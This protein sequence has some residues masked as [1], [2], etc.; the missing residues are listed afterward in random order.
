MASIDPNTWLLPFSSK[1]YNFSNGDGRPWGDGT[2]MAAREGLP[3]PKDP[4]DTGCKVTPLI[5][6]F[7]TMSAIRE[8]LKKAIAFAKAQNTPLGQRGHVYIAGL[9][10]NS[11]RDLSVHNDWHTDPWT[12]AQ[13][14]NSDETAIGLILQLLQAGIQ[15][16]I[17]L[18]LP[19]F[20]TELFGY[21]AHI[22][23][24]YYLADIVRAECERLSKEFNMPG[25]ASLGIV[26]LDIRV[27][28][29]IS[30]AHHQKMLL[31]RV[32]DTN[33]AY[34]G[35]VDLVFTRRDA[36]LWNDTTGT[37]NYEYDPNRWE[38][39]SKPPPQFLAG[40]WQ[41][42]TGIPTLFDLSDKTHRWPTAAGVNY[43]V[44]GK[45]SPFKAK[46]DSDLPEVYGKGDRPETRQ[47]WHDQHLR[48]EGPIVKT[49]EEQFRERWID[50]GRVYD[51]SNIYSRANW[52]DNQVIFSTNQA[53]DND[54]NIKSLDQ[55]IDVPPVPGGTSTVQMWRTIPLRKRK[56]TQTPLFTRGEFTIMA[57][58]A[59]ACQTATQ[60][61]W[62]FDQYFFSRP[63]GKLLNV[64]VNEKKHDPL[65]KQNLYILVILPPFADEHQLQEHNARKFVLN[66]LTADLTYKEIPGPPKYRQY[67]RVGIYNIWHPENNDRTKGRGIYCH[68]KAQMYD[69]AL[70]VCGSANLNHKSLTNDTELDCAVL[71]P[72]LVDRHQQWL[73]KV[74]FPNVPWPSQIN[75]NGDSWGK[76]FFTAFQEASKEEHNGFLIPDPWWD[77]QKT[78]TPGQVPDPINPQPGAIIKVTPPKLPNSV[79]REQ[80]FAEDYLD[81]ARKALNNPNLS[82]SELMLE[83]QKEQGASLIE[84]LI[85]IHLDPSSLTEHVETNVCGGENPDNAG[86]LDMIVKLIEGCYY[87]DMQGQLQWP[88]RKS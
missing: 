27:A 86:R 59:H 82:A 72:A 32:G 45:V 18:W 25:L 55:A 19:V 28:K 30:A 31:I 63:L 66:D 35:G 84:E 75:F 88:W 78:I 62:I 61:I 50:V 15:V 20:I 6:G 17:L 69:R 41:S 10:L 73:W 67:D 83:G 64:L 36:P 65:Y 87:K 24:H 29:P 8:D 51:L 26:G 52:F 38:D 70:L 42:G 16:R 79:A 13:S 60:L 3:L 11:L 53:Y 68:T 33:V 46:Q 57:G 48:L 37:Y 74:F 81:D 5:G 4:W 76:D 54:K 44:V 39:L 2:E 9:R 34:C 7:E 49:L 71:D 21:K 77:T 14:A 22:Q 80:D 58:I 1:T 12:P 43:E 23:D 47:I 40:D 56:K 85:K